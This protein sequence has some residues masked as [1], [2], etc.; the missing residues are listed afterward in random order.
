MHMADRAAHDDAH[1]L[2]VRRPDPARVAHGMADVVA[3]HGALLA[4]LAVLAHG[5]IPPY[6]RDD[7]C[8][9]LSKRL[10]AFFAGPAIGL[11]ARLRILIFI[12]FI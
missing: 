5:D 12:I 3:G 7:Y 11:P 6:G 10:Q 2:G 8:S 4:N 1:T 9:I